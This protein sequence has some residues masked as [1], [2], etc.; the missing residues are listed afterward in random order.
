MCLTERL[1]QRCGLS[2]SCR[3]HDGLTLCVHPWKDN[4]H[5]QDGSA[6]T[7]LSGRIDPKTATSVCSSRPTYRPTATPA[8][9]YA[10]GPRY[11]ISHITTS[12]FNVTNGAQGGIWRGSDV[13]RM[14]GAA[15]KSS[16]PFDDPR[17]FPACSSKRRRLPTPLYNDRLAFSDASRRRRRF[18]V[19]VNG[20]FHSGVWRGH[21]RV[22]EGPCT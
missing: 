21:S 19:L 14:D 4:R 13:K 2:E 1:S 7:A 18:D 22:A 15:K 17:Q 3:F 20:I 8:A 5:S 10:R 11:A 6:G 12:V 16:T 9:R